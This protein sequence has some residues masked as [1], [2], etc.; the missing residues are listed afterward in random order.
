MNPGYSAKEEVKRAVDIVEL[1]GQ[2]V[3]LKRAGQNYVGLCPFHQEKDPSFTVSPSK[4]IFHC[5]GCRK[6]GDVFAFWMEYHKVSFPEAL[7]DLAEK[8]NVPLPK[9]SPAAADQEKWSERASL[10]KVNEA[11]CGH[12]HRLLMESAQGKPG[13]EYLERRG[14]SREVL[15]SFK[16][17]YAPDEWDSLCRVIRKGDLEKAQQAGLLVPKK[18]GGFYDR[19]RSRVMFPIFD[20]RGRILGF[21]GRVLGDASPKYLNTPES[22]L[23]HKGRVLYGLHASYEAIRKSGRVVIV[24]GYMDL[25]ALRRHGFQ[26]VV[27]TLGTA[28][29]REHVRLLK[30]YA[31]EA[32]V[33]FDAD[34]AGKTA[35]AKSLSC[36]LDEGLQ[37]K[38]L[39]LPENEDPDSFVN[40]NGLARFRDLLDRA[41]PIFDFFVDLRF[42]SSGNSIEGKVAAIKEILPLLATLK[43]APQRSFYVRRLSEKLGVRESA[44][45]EEMQ[46]WITSRSWQGRE[47]S[48]RQR[49]SAPKAGS[50]NDSM[51]LN[52]LVHHPKASDGLMKEEFRALLSDPVVREI[53]EVMMETYRS[54][55]RFTP[56]EILERIEGENARQVLR[57]TLMGPSICQPDEVSQAV[58]ELQDKIH[59]MKITETKGRALRSGDIREL[60]EIPKRIRKKWG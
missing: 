32:I 28:L 7:R 60:S 46:R 17:G 8:Y 9:G 1:I 24:E 6:G 27:A 51:I 52:L 36:F 43:D 34:L 35:A 25:L 44:V 4:Q 41:V 49:L 11:A 38:A 48:L 14:M 37:A 57:E 15:S 29:T 22:P 23:F 47:T 10:L 16:L 3:Q 40:R 21:G 30:G 59:R 56:E 13:R 42:S 39:L 26:E 54:V 58:Q 18:N 45:I 50:Q 12:Y 53:F 33:V 19:F 2:S 20:L 31:G 55:K 5:Y